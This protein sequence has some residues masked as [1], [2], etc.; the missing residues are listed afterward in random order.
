MTGK[1]DIDAKNALVRVVKLT[2]AVPEGQSKLRHEV[3]S[4][5]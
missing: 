5:H 3:G 2:E 4:G 1:T